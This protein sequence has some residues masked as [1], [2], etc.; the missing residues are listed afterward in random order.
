MDKISIQKIWSDADF[1]EIEVYAQSELICSK[2]NSYTTAAAINELALHLISF[3]EN[4]HDKYIWKNGIK[5]DESTPFISLEFWC[6]D[7]LGHIV[8]EVYMEIDDGAPYSRHNCCYFIN[9]EVGLL[10]RFGNGLLSLNNA[11]VGKKITLN[12]CNN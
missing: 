4:S 1:F 5:G 3:P 2:V 10:N 7:E 9:T 8:V 6:K 11:E 12:E